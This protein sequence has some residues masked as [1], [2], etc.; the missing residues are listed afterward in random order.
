MKT[1]YKIFAILMIAVCTLVIMPNNMSLAAGSSSASDAISNIPVSEPS[2]VTTGLSTVIGKLLGFLQVASGL[3]AVLMIAIV[4][5]NY[6][7]ST[8]EIKDEMK[9]KMLP[10]II[11]IVLVFGATSIA[12]FLIGVA[13]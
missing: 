2:G 13:G 4:G 3:V 7:I 1:V 10:I 9:K 6:I 11:G 8:P 12:K 5:F